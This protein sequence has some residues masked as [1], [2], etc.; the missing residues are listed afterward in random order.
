MPNPF[1]DAQ[2]VVDYIGRGTITDPGMLIAIDAACDM[3][4]TVAEM[5]FNAGTATVSLDGT[6]TDCLV[7][8][9]R[10]VNTVGTVTVAAGT[11]TDWMVTDDGGLLRGAAGVDPRPVW[12]EGRQNVSVTYSFGYEA[13]DLPRDVRAV[14]L[15]AAARF[16]VQG[17]AKKETV[18]DVTVEYATNANDLTTNELRI[19]RKYRKARSF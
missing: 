14:A 7:L 9:Q 3:C 11:I 5:D 13:V 15:Q 2:D 19:L 10:P 17:V 18:G 1:I 8:P 6:G 4:R 12:P 16:I